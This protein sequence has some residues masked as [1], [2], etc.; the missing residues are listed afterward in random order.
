MTLHRTTASSRILFAALA[1]GLVLCTACDRGTKTTIVTSPNPAPSGFGP[2]PGGSTTGSAASPGATAT[3]TQAT[4]RPSGNPK[5]GSAA[6][7]DPGTDA[8]KY[9]TVPPYTE[10]R[11]AAIRG[12][13]RSLTFTLTLGAEL[14]D[15]T[16]DANTTFKAGFRV[17]IG[18]TPYVLTANGSSTGWSA[19]ATKGGKG[20]AFPG[21]L[22]RGGA[23]LTFVVPWTFFGGAQTFTWTGFSA[24]DQSGATTRFYSVDIIPNSGEAPYPMR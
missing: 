12:T 16:P 24:Y 7:Q 18:E 1:V 2:G 23:A 5:S 15:K 17:K 9:G 4:A 8:L 14:P 6:L 10:I 11:A 3:N 13:S 22:K 20:V 21:T 19:S